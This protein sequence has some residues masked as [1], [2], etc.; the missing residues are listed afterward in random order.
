[1]IAAEITQRQIW[2]V[3]TTVATMLG[4]SAIVFGTKRA[5]WAVGLVVLAFPHIIG[6]PHPEAFGGTVPPELAAEFA[7][8]S[9]AVGSVGWITLGVLAAY[10]WL[11]ENA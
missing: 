9:L 6:A 1:M 3:G 10:F 11:K 5:H 8:R 4:I 7:A 2:T